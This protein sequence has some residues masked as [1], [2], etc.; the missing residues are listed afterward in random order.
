MIKRIILISVFLFL[1]LVI[2]SPFNAGAVDIS[3]PCFNLPGFPPCGE[4]ATSSIA[5]YI[6]RFYQFAVGI[7]GIIAVGAIV[8]GAIMIAVSGGKPD[9][10]KEG[11]DIIVSA[12]WGVVLL[13]GVTLILRTINPRMAAL[14]EPEVPKIPECE[15]AEEDKEK[16]TPLRTPCIPPKFTYASMEI[17]GDTSIKT[18]TIGDYEKKLKTNPEQYT[19]CL[20]IPGMSETKPDSK[21]PSI[22]DNVRFEE[23]FIRSN[24][25]GLVNLDADLTKFM[26]SEQ[27]RWLKEKSDCKVQPKMNAALLKLKKLVDADERLTPFSYFRIYEITEAFPPTA[28]HTSAEHYNGCAVD[29]TLKAGGCRNIQIFVD[30][31]IEAGFSIYNEYLKI[32]PE[33]KC[34]SSGSICEGKKVK[35]GHLHLSLPI[36]EGKCP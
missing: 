7:V 27:C 19:H 2:V 29:V 5:L 15:Y 28:S 16:K 13:L 32:C 24:F 33:I 9:K 10:Q 14:I 25:D 26:K 12:V 4:V 11:K 31:A 34:P 3:F 22:L 18:T 6:S 1:A 20:S 8:V 36:K 17:P 23:C 21:I 30:K 35:D